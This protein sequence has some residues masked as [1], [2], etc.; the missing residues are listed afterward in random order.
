MYVHDYVH[1]VLC[2]N[3][4]YKQGVIYLVI[5]HYQ[6]YEHSACMYFEFMNNYVQYIN[7]DKK[8]VGEG[9]GK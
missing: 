1:N 8:R 6:V 2:N 4:V 5:I 7:N 3:N 9:E